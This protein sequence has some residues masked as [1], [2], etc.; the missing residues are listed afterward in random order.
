MFRGTL[1]SLLELVI[2]DLFEE[3]FEYLADSENSGILIAI[4][5]NN[6][7]MRKVASSDLDKYPDMKILEG[8]CLHFS[9][10]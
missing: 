5:E 1:I 7:K 3:K 4:L 9:E 10:S 8:Q 6:N 2:D